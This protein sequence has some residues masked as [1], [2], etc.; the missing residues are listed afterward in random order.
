MEHLDEVRNEDVS[1]LSDTQQYVEDV[2]L[3]L[4][5]SVHNFTK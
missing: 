5:T 3:S 2:R 4:W 1:V